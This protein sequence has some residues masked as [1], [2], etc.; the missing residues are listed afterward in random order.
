MIITIELQM[1][2]FVLLLLDM[3]LLVLCSL[4]LYQML[5]QH[6]GI[7][8]AKLNKTPEQ[9]RIEKSVLKAIIMQ[10]LLP[11][12]CAVPGFFVLL[13]VIFQ[14]WNSAALHLTIFSYGENRQYHYTTTHLCI[15]IV[16]AVPILDPFI[17]LRVVKS[18]RRAASQFLA[19]FKI[20]KKF[21]GTSVEQTVTVTVHVRPRLRV[22]VM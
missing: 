19:K 17:T 3:P 9:I 22:S 1:F 4:R 8:S 7:V 12:I 14:G 20:C 2:F 6:I 15:F 10:S 16:A 11:M 13:M 21:T 5:S 18:Y